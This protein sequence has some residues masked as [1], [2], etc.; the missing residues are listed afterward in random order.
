MTACRWPAA[1]AQAQQHGHDE[2]A[3]T[4]AGCSSLGQL[5]QQQFP[6]LPA[7]SQVANVRGAV[8]APPLTASG[9]HWQS[10]T[11]CLTMPA[12]PAVSHIIRDVAAKRPGPI[13]RSGCRLEQGLLHTAWGCSEAQ[14]H[15]W[16]PMLV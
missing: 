1:L 5:R 10:H 3:G 6:G 8:D 16:L 9:L 15:E 14:T 13:T 7:V 12:L 2:S 11:S 4:T